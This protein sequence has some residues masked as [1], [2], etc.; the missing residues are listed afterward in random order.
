MVNLKSIRNKGKN[1]KDE[2]VKIVLDFSIIN[3]SKLRK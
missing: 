3:L 1:K 2:N